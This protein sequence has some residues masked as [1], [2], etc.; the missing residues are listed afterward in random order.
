[1]RAQAHHRLQATTCVGQYLRA[2]GI[3]LLLQTA[4]RLPAL[5]LVRELRPASQLEPV[6]ERHP[7]WFLTVW[8]RMNLPGEPPNDPKRAA[9]IQSD[10]KWD[11]AHQISDC[12]VRDD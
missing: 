3:L 4:F 1:M 8:S 2:P 5:P 11:N 7:N 12:A 6:D 10:P 9:T